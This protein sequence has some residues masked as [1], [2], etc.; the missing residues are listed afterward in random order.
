MAVTLAAEDVK[1]RVSLD[2]SE[3]GV[4]LPPDTEPSEWAG[5]RNLLA[6][7]MLE[8]IPPPYDPLYLSKWGKLLEPHFPRIEEAFGAE[9]YPVSPQKATTLIPKFL[10]A[11]I[12][13][14]RGTHLRGKVIAGFS[15]VAFAFQGLA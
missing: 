14:N 7:V 10:V 5:V 4:A 8:Y 1:I 6:A 12:F 3:Y 13:S 11:A 9:R 15:A 2:R